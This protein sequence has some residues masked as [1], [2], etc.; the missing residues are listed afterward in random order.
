MY[1]VTLAWILGT[2]VSHFPVIVNG[3]NDIL[4]NDIWRLPSKQS[5]YWSS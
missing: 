2:I 5:M 3:E 4:N 1:I